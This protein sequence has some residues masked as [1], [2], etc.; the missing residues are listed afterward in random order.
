M[1]ETVWQ[2]RFVEV[3]KD[4]DWEYVARRDDIDAAVIVAFDGDALLLVEQMRVPL[5][6]PCLELPAGLVGDEGEPESIAA[7]AARELEEETG[8]RAATVETL[9]EFHSSPGMTSERFTIVR[10][11]GLTRVG[12]VEAGITLH[13]VPPSDLPAFIAARRKAGIAMD[14]KLLLVLSLETLA[15]AT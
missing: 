9:G 3:R 13:R 7:A 5:G 4:G 2:G 11:T 6:R 14:A 8:Y 15:A 12:P 1:T 10:A